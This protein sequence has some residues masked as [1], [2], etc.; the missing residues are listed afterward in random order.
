MADDHD[1]HDH[2]PQNTFVE[3]PVHA[4]VFVLVFLVAYFLSQYEYT[5]NDFAKLRMT[6]GAAWTSFDKVFAATPQQ[7]FQPG[8]KDEILEVIRAAAKEKVG[9]KVVGSG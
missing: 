5:E 8:T 1:D 4:T 3:H 6:K 9:V 2:P 7:W